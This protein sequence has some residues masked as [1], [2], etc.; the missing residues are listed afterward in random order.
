MGRVDAFHRH[1]R[2]AARAAQRGDHLTRRQ[3]AAYDARMDLMYRRELDLT[4]VGEA[5][6]PRSV[7]S[8]ALLRDFELIP[9]AS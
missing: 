2:H 5:E 1:P 6:G 8:L 9:I 7:R 4:H 3:I